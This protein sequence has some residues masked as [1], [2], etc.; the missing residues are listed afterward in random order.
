MQGR[1]FISYRRID[2][3]YATDQIYDQLVRHFGSGNVFMDIDTIPLGVNFREYIDQ[4]VSTSDIV[5]AVIGDHWLSA[6]DPDGNPRLDNPNDFVRLEIEAALKQGIKLIP[7]FIGGVQTLPASRLPE[8]L[9]ELP[10]LNATRIRRSTDFIP[11]VKRLIRALENIRTEQADTRERHSATLLEV[12][13]CIPTL[14]EKL[15]SLQDLSVRQKRQQKKLEDEIETLSDKIAD[16]LG[17]PAHHL[18]LDIGQIEAELESLDDQIFNLSLQIEEDRKSE[19]LAAAQIAREK[20]EAERRDTILRENQRELEAIRHMVSEILDELENLSGLAIRERRNQTSIKRSASLTLR[21]LQR[22]LESREDLVRADVDIYRKE[23]DDLKNSWL[24]FTTSLEERKLKEEIEDKQRKEARTRAEKEEMRKSEEITAARI[25][26]QEAEEERQAARRKENQRELQSI[27]HLVEEINTELDQLSGLTG[28]ERRKQ[29]TVKRSSGLTLKAIQRIIDSPDELLRVDVYVYREELNQIKSDWLDLTTEIEERKLKEEK[30]EKERKQAEEQAITAPEPVKVSPKP[31]A[32]GIGFLQRVPTWGWG[33]VVIVVAVAVALPLFWEQISA[34]MASTTQ[35]V[36]TTTES[37]DGSGSSDYSLQLS[38]SEE[39]LVD[40]VDEL[41]ATTPDVIEDFSVT[42]GY[43][44]STMVDEDHS[45]DDYIRDGSMKIV[46]QPDQQLAYTVNPSDAQYYLLAFEFTPITF[47]S[48]I[49][50]DPARLEYMFFEGRDSQYRF[51]LSQ[52][53]SWSL[54]FE[55]L[56]IA[57][58]QTSALVAGQTYQIRCLSSREG[59]VA[60]WVDGELLVFWGFHPDV[61]NSYEISFSGRNQ[62]EVELDNFK[63]WDLTGFRQGEFQ[64]LLDQ[65]KQIPDKATN[66]YQNVRQYLYETGPTFHEDFSSYQPYMEEIQPVSRWDP[67]ITLS[68]FVGNG[69]VYHGSNQEL[70][71][72]MRFPQ[73]IGGDAAIQFDFH[74]GGEETN[75]AI[76]VFKMAVES[77]QDGNQLGYIFSLSPF[78]EEEYISWEILRHTSPEVPS[79]TMFESDLRS[80]PGGEYKHTLLLIFSKGQFGGFLDGQF[81]GYLDGLDLG[82]QQLS[83]GAIADNNL[84]VHFDNIKYWDLTYLEEK[85][86]APEELKS[87]VDFLTIRNP[88]FEENFELPQSYWDQMPVASGGQEIGMLSE[89]IVDGALRLEN[90]DLFSL[91]FPQAQGSNFAMQFDFSYPDP[92]IT[93][94][95]IDTTIFISGETEEDQE[96][97]IPYCGYQ[98]NQREI[99]CGIYETSDSGESIDIVGEDFPVGVPFTKE[100]N[101]PST[102]LVIYTQGQLALFLDSTLKAYASDLGTFGQQATIHISKGTPGE[103]YTIEIDNIK[104]WDLDDMLVDIEGN[105]PDAE[106]LEYATQVFSITDLNPP[107]FEEDYETPQSYWDQ[108]R[109]DHDSNQAPIYVSDIVLDG[110]LH[111]DTST[112]SSN[113]TF[114]LLF[115]DVRAENFAYEFDFKTYADGG[116]H[117]FFGE[118]NDGTEA[119][120]VNIVVS[121]EEDGLFWSLVRTSGTEEVAITSGTLD[122]SDITTSQHRLG[123]YADSDKL[124]VLLDG[125]VLTYQTGLV[126]RENNVSIYSWDSESNPIVEFDNFKFWDLNRIAPAP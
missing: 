42:Q 37:D 102:F 33:V 15:I 91:Q 122:P 9:Q 56:T 39:N 124:L 109:V 63:L 2:S 98:Q 70:T 32:K 72:D 67:N 100:I 66:L 6:A 5:L 77:D 118:D 58:G 62:I 20:A 24:D 103:K 27:H 101:I 114:S 110:V 7:L 3:Q 49:L 45:L 69:A 34:L 96:F 53:G 52:D 79:T 92:G 107:D 59:F 61:L 43:W 22:I 116:V 115:E 112:F 81:L 4:Q 30:E 18:R 64:S 104:F 60:L 48:S 40:L 113:Q 108:M 47:E 86:E 94:D 28:K 51:N 75:Q 68:E 84:D 78:F 105:L 83:I 120:R 71:F 99:W 19:Q 23:F 87:V 93:K 50:G 85:L 16:L 31:V 26:A 35:P 65:K 82:D 55:D 46:E 17:S 74:L 57:E 73:M 121:E 88:K 76:N 111:I 95:I 126:F 106:I 25:A 14:R 11:D 125:K 97:Y 44:Y 117:V 80:G 38:E 10:M 119:Y 13:N 90:S 89:L 41:V 21:T 12:Q 29:T 1:I 123:L 8:S 36:E 54:I